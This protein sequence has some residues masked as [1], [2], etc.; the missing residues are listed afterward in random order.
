MVSGSEDGSVYFFDVESGALVNKLQG[1]SSPTLCICWTYDESSL[2]SCDTEVR[3]PGV[4]KVRDLV[5]SL[6]FCVFFCRALSSFGRGSK[7]VAAPAMNPHPNNQRDKATP[8]HLQTANF[9]DVVFI[10]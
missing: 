3:Y 2:A 9:V 1:H 7:D 4:A 5:I 10:Y 6:F 8:T